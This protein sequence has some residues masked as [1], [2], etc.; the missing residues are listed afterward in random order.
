MGFAKYDVEKVRKV[1]EAVDNNE[2]NMYY[3]DMGVN[4]QN[5]ASLE[6]ALK[7]SGLDYTVEKKP[8]Q[9]MSETET[10]W[11]GQSVKVSAPFPIENMFATVRSDNNQFM[12][13]V[14]KGYEILQNQEAFDFLDSMVLS[15]AKF[16]TAG[17]Y[18]TNSA[19]N[20]ITMSTEPMKILDDNFLPT[21]MFLNSHDGTK[22]IQVM[23]INVRIFCSNCIARAK[24]GAENS[25]NIR[26]SRSMRDKMDIARE[27][28][29]AQTNYFEALKKEAE[30]LAVKPFSKEAFE[31]LARELFP[32]KEEDSEIVQI[33]N[34]AKV[35]QLLTAYRQ[36]DLA[37]FN[38]TAWGAIQAV[39]D[40]ESH[41][42][43]MRK[44]KVNGGFTNVVNAMPLLNMVWERV[45]A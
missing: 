27:V 44:T 40:F 12:G 13:I 26:H 1:L 5:V 15:G 9:F 45:A 16:E 18:G 17:S 24:K 30:K 22:S 37:N 34:L 43:N 20:F 41:P 36:D 39:A 11:N 6:T 8:L 10:V 14:G 29:L 7:L 31:S 25:I 21:M 4:L 42:V 38:N 23:Y 32:V 33:R 2:R 35:E 3:A 28:L 19:K